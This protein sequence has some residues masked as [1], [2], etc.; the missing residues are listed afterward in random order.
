[1]LTVNRTILSLFVFVTLVVTGDRTG[2]L[3]EIARMQRECCRNLTD[4]F[5]IILIG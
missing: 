3:F 2:T 4:I 5:S 1:M